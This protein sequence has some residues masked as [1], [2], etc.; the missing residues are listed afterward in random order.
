MQILDKQL[1]DLSKKYEQDFTNL[2]QDKKEL[3]ETLMPGAAS[4]GLASAY[5]KEKDKIQESIKSWNSIFKCSVVIFILVFALYFWL[6]FDEK[7]SYVSF[8]KSLPLWIFSG[9]FS[10]YLT[11]SEE[12][13]VGKECRSRWSPYH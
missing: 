9:F 12:R 4:V 3:I 11:R 8:L 2:Y 10:F 13:R 7:F 1:Q 5:Q 6:S